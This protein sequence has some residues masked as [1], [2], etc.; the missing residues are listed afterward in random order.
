MARSVSGDAALV[1]ERLTRHGR[2]VD[3]LVADDVAEELVVRQF[4]FDEV[5]IS[6][7]ADPAHAM[8]QDDLV[9]AFVDVRVFDDA[10]ERRP[11]RAG[12]EQ[13]QVLA[14]LQ[15]VDDQ[16]AHGLTADQDGVA[17]FQ[18]LQSRRKRTVL[19]LDAE[20]FEVFFVVRTGDA[21]GPQ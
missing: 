1:A 2:V 21:V 11:A 8:N 10:H 6:Q 4:L 19:H 16:R 7:F 14:R 12:A 15:V 13:E 9:E 5:S 17:F 20:E 18:M 3:E